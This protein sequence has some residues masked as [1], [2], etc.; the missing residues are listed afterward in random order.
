MFRIISFIVLN[1]LSL[2]ASYLV[3]SNLH[4]VSYDSLHV[5]L[6]QTTSGIQPAPYSGCFILVSKAAVALM[7]CCDAGIITVC[8]E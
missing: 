3:A 6:L 5:F 2:I 7:S 1:I 8:I 4:L